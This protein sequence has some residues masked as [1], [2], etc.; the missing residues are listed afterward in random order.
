MIINAFHQRPTTQTR[1]ANKPCIG[2]RERVDNAINER[3]VPLA[4]QQSR[5]RDVI[6]AR[7]K[8]RQ[9]RSAL[10]ERDVSRRNVGDGR[11]KVGHA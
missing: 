10:V 4:A 5:K 7:H 8:R 1:E 11:L 9:Q 3:F 2:E 6:E